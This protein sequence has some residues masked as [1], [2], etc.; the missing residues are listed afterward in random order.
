MSHPTPEQ[1]AELD[2][3]QV[4]QVNK[5]LASWL[6]ADLASYNQMQIECIWQYSYRVRAFLTQVDPHYINCSET[7]EYLAELETKL[8]GIQ[9]WQ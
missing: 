9:S 8:C 6:A 5:K 7:H 2:R 4:R 3:E 1:Q